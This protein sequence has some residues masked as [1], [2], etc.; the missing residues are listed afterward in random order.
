MVIRRTN[1]EL[2]QAEAELHILEGLKI[3]LD[4]I[5]EVITLIRSSFDKTEAAAKLQ[6]RFALSAK[7]AEA[8]LQ[9]RLQT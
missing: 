2:R 4:H 6:A 9:M 3:A 7:Q 8:I 5:D 1:F